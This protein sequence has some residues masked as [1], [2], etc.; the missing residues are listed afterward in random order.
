MALYLGGDKVE[1]NLDGNTYCLNLCFMS[2]VS[3]DIALIS[4]DNYILKSMDDLYLIPR[5]ESVDINGVIAVSL[6]N[7]ILT[8]INKVYLTMKEDD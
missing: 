8:D 2:S 3:N 6:D 7:Y 1:I 5:N 4:S